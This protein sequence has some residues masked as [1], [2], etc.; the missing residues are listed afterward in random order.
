MAI[1]EMSPATVL[2]GPVAKNWW[3]ILLRGLAAIAFGLVCFVVPVIGLLAM[4]LLYGVYALVDGT[5]AMIWGSR[6]HWPAMVVVG[7]ISVLSGLIA[8][9]WPGITALALLYVIAAWAI[10]RGVAEI[11]A[12]VHLRRRIENEW[13]L[14][15][16]G[17]ASVVFGVLIALFP[18]AGALS[19]LWLIGSL[20]IVFGIF[21]V[22]L[23]VRLRSL[24]PTMRPREEET[25]VGVAS[26]D[27]RLPD[28]HIR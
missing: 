1:N 8:L 26:D 2:L 25:P 19:V 18:G 11:Y 3:L 16:S 24:Q 13:L 5:S 12:A 20:A 27:D 9:F 6:S 22:L 21:V 15:L 10:V 4:V 14:A 23:A 7:A 28:E 17:V